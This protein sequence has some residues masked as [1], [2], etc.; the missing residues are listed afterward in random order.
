MSRTHRFHRFG[1]TAALT[2]GLGILIASGSAWA[3]EVKFSAETLETDDNGN[4]TKDARAG[5]KGKVESVAPDE[6]LWQL[7]VWAKIDKGAQGPL[8][9]EFYREHAGKKLMAYSHEEPD[10][11]G[12]KYWSMNIELARDMGF[13]FDDVLSVEVLQIGGNDK[14]KILAKGKL[15]LAKSTKQ[16]AP[17][18]GGGGGGGGSDDVDEGEG[19]EEVDEQDA[20]DS[21]AGP[22]EEEEEEEAEPDAP[23]EGPPPV[24]SESKKG[25]RVD[26]S[27]GLPWA[28]AVLLALGLVARKD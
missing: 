26:S 9:V 13:R 4:L 15:T 21:L 2:V 18:G 5:A 11:D 20:R 10:Y 25:C 12:G 14:K 28:L 8:Y 27:G 23:A 16:P 7:S 24:D 17:V 6:E 19:E 3:G 22:E 1:R